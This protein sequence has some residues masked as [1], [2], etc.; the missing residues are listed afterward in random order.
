MLEVA[1]IIKP[2][3]TRGEM[4]VEL[5]TNRPERLASDAVLFG[6]EAEF[7]VER[8]RPFAG[9]WLVWFV[10]VHTFAAA[11][12]L[13]NTVLS[14]PPLE[15]PD[16]LWVHDLLDAEVQDL[17]GTALGTVVSV[18]ANPASDLLELDSGGL[19]PLHFVVE[20]RLSEAGG[21]RVVVVD[22]PPGLFD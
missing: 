22:P 6:P 13:R 21:R 15:D 18:M 12:A 17:S 8:S 20:S 2:H 19:V 11:E 9:R 3:G 4:V 1:R 14:A 7:V 16:A 5:L 10:G